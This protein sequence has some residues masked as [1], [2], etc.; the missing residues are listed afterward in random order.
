MRPQRAGDRVAGEGGVFGS[1][2]AKPDR[3]GAVDPFAGTV[4]G[5]INIPE[6]YPLEMLKSVFSMAYERG[7]KGCTVF[8]PNQTTRS[9]LS[10]CRTC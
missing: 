9:I 10:K 3:A 5:T 6:N 1:L 2:E 8:R 4:V 7:L